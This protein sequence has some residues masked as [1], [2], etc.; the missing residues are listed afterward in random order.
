MVDWDDELEQSFKVKLSVR[1]KNITGAFAQVAVVIAENGSN[2]NHVDLHEGSDAEK[3]IDFL[4]DVTDRVHFAR[5]I[6]A[7]YR[8]PLV[9]RVHR[10]KG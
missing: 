4:I 6:K 1:I 10:L 8:L 2:L 9:E 7:I 3:Q 5:I